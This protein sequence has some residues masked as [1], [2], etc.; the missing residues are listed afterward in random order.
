MDKTNIRSKEVLS[1]YQLACITLMANIGLYWDIIEADKLL[2]N[3]TRSTAPCPKEVAN[4]ARTLARFLASQG[5]TVN[6]IDSSLYFRLQYCLNIHHIMPSESLRR[7]YAHIFISAQYRLLFFPAPDPSSTSFC[8]PSHWKPDHILEYQRRHAVVCKWKD[9]EDSRYDKEKT[10]PTILQHP[11][12][13]SDLPLAGVSSM[14]IQNAPSG[15]M[16]QSL[17]EST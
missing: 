9:T 15:P 7:R 4:N 13:S 12:S 5:V 14:L 16:G 3:P 8:I 1:H 11:T 17:P 2:I 6:E 10:L